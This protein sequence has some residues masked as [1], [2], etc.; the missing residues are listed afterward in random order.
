MF[1]GNVSDW[2][3]NKTLFLNWCA[4]Y[5]NLKDLTGKERPD[6]EIIESD[7]LLDKHLDA[8]AQER[9]RKNFENKF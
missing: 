7:Y 3:I 9:E 2:D 5:Y 4:F 1:A 6:A 8:I